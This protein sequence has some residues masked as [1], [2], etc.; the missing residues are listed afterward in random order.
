MYLHWP[1]GLWAMNTMVAAGR[2]GRRGRS[3]RS[4]RPSGA[5]QK[6]SSKRAGELHLYL[7]HLQGVGQQTLLQ[8][9]LSGCRSCLFFWRRLQP[10]LPCPPHSPFRQ[11]FPCPRHGEDL[12]YPKSGERNLKNIVSI[13]SFLMLHC[14]ICRIE[15]LK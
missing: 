10:A 12:R 13:A 6:S 5:G 4:T 1:V 9:S 7:V 8:D 11:R 15:C 3:D 2:A 14:K